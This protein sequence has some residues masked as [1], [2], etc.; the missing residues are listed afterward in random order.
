MLGTDGTGGGSGG[1]GKAPGDYGQSGDA[2]SGIVLIKRLT[3][4]S[5]TASGGTESE[6][7]DYTYHSFTAVGSGAYTA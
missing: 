3:A 2:G 4:D 5:A 6:S 7:G 1:G